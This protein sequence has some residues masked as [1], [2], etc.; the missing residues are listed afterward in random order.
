MKIYIERSK[1]TKEIN[2]DKIKVKELLKLLNIPE[3]TVL[4]T[5]NNELVTEDSILEKKDNIKLLSVI[6]GG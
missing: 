6:S 3:N 5:K 1:E 2:K 4:V